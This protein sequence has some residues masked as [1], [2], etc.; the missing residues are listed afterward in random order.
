[1]KNA[2]LSGVQQGALSLRCLL[3]ALFF[4]LILLLA[5]VDSLMDVFQ[6]EP[7]SGFHGKLICDAVKTDAA[8]FFV[9]ILST[10]P[11]AA[12]YVEEI[13]S[14]YARSLLYRSSRAAY[15][16]GKIT[17]CFAS[18]GLVLVLGILLAYAL[19]AVV[20]IPV[21][22]PL[23]NNAEPTNWFQT[24]LP[25]LGLYFLSGGLW[26][27]VGMTASTWMESRYIAYAAPFVLYYVLIML[28]ERY[29]PTF[30][31]LDPRA[32][33]LPS[34]RWIGEGWGAA[35]LVMELSAVSALIFC[36]R[37]GRRLM[38]L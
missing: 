9:P 17:A 26:A 28:Y 10:L 2:I 36:L 33:L 32:W 19:S 4:A 29:F 31:V 37:A 23:S 22:A 3:G 14:K 1:M 25:S 12:R 8:R 11:F 13:K 38:E 15:L 16:A 20:L 34:P 24:L 27:L 7:V 35:L 21:E 18:G 30:Y 5:S 6:T